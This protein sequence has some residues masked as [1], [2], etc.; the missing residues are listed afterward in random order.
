[1]FPVPVFRYWKVNPGQP[2]FQYFYNY[3]IT[4]ATTRYDN[5]DA[6]GGYVKDKRLE[7]ADMLD[8]AVEV[9][10]GTRLL[11]QIP[12][13]RVLVISDEKC[14]PDAGQTLHHGDNRAR[15]MPVIKPVVLLP[16]SIK[17]KVSSAYLV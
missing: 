6:F 9:G 13:S 12:N 2:T 8:I 5:F 11:V 17:E 14:H 15:G 3:V 1:L 10:C 16:K 7:V 4:V